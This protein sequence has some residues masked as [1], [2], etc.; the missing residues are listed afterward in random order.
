MGYSDEKIRNLCREGIKEGWLYFKMKVGA[1][2]QDDIR[3]GK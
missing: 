3:C 1:D 2:L